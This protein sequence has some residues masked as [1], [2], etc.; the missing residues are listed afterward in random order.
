[1]GTH[2]K[3]SLKE[4]NALNSYIKLVR[5]FE[6]ISSNLYVK[7]AKE[8]LTESQFYLL[9]ALYNLGPLYQKDLAKKICRSEGNIT[10]VVNNLEKRDLIKKKQSEDDKRI[11]MIKLNKNGKEL[12]EKVF[13][14]F[15]KAIMTEF[16][17]IKEKEHREFQKI[18]K[19]VGLKNPKHKLPSSK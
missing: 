6:S 1:M 17:V 3:G 13:P 14:K 10:M 18:C 9:D 16:S 2:Y 7:F 4:T 15:L 5:A 12:Y 19:K 11:F 8:N